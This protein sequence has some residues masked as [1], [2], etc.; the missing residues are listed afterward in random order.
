MAPQ[1]QGQCWLKCLLSATVLYICCIGPRDRASCRE[2]FFSS[3]FLSAGWNTYFAATTPQSCCISPRYRSSIQAPIKIFSA[4]LLICRYHFID[5]LHRLLR[6]RASIHIAGWRAY[7]SLPFSRS[8]ASA[9]EIGPVYMHLFLFC[10]FDFLLAE[11]L[12][13][14]YHK[15]G[16]VECWV[17]RLRPLRVPEHQQVSKQSQ[18]P[19]EG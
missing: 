5:L 2:L 11:I 9:P 3:F 1:R 7:F 6:D 15:Q 8:V 19:V 13:C 14:R 17:N 4:D 18:Q 16:I 12:I 10:F